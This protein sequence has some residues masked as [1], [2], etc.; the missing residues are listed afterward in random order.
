MSTRSGPTSSRETPAARCWPRAGPSTEWSS[1]RSPAPATLGTPSRAARYR[2]PSGPPPAARPPSR[3]SRGIARS[4]ER[5][6]PSVAGVSC[7]SAPGEG[8]RALLG[9]GA[10]ALAV[11]VGPEAGF[12][13]RLH[14]GQIAP[15]GGPARL[16]DRR[17]GRGDGERRVLSA[18]LG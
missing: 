3:S 15:V 17:F 12:D 9:K 13:H 5:P 11:V 14:P 6:A 7:G 8:G 16:A 1:R 2:P 10:L 18:V 4:D